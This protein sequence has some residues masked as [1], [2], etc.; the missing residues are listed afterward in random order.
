[1]LAEFIVLSGLGWLCDLVSFALLIKACGLPDFAAN[2]IS[3]YVGI[4]FVW[5]ASLG[6]VFGVLGF[7]TGRFLFV[8]WVFQ[9]FSILA[10][11]QFLHMVVG[12]L[13]TTK[14]FSGEV[15]I[16]AKIIVTPFNLITNFL[17][18]KALTFRMNSRD[19]SL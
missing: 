4:T 17:F 10:Y 6:R 8:Y 12:D 5:F 13:N 16:A 19:I 18:M 7:R 3:S 1:M 2:F 15:E 9:F 11:S 14:L